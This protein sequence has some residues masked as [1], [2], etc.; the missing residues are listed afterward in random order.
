MASPLTAM[1]FAVRRGGTPAAAFDGGQ[2]AV[3]PVLLAGSALGRR[4][5]LPHATLEGELVLE[6]R[7]ATAKEGGWPFPL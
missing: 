2:A 3:R 4:R 1:P 7:L 6:A 5:K